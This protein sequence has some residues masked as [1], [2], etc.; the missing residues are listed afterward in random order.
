MIVGWSGPLLTSRMRCTSS[1]GRA[2]TRRE[3]SPQSCQD[4]ESNK[5]DMHLQQLLWCSSWAQ[6]L[7]HYNSLKWSDPTDTLNNMKLKQNND[8]Q[9]R[10]ST[11]KIDTTNTVKYVIIYILV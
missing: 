1:G 3:E 6:Q 7:R 9:N 8:E 11:I 10:I 2:G 4:G 5:G